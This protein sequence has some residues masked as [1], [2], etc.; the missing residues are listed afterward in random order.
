VSSEKA[1]VLKQTG[2]AGFCQTVGKNRFFSVVKTGLAKI[3]FASKNW[4]PPAKIG[5]RQNMFSSKEN[6]SI[7]VCISLNELSL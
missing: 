1:C 2:L 6:S 3:V 5:F 7:S 4:F